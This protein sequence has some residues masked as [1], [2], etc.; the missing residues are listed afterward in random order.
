MEA[1]HLPALLN[2]KVNFTLSLPVSVHSMNTSSQWA[3]L[4][5]K[6][7]SHS[8][9][10]CDIEEHVTGSPIEARIRLVAPV[11]AFHHIKS[12]CVRD[13][14]SR[15][16]EFSNISEKRQEELFREVF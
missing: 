15:L 6:S 7:S 5:Q 8:L 4:N 3:N 16:W 2:L 11:L 12:C 13:I 14:R 10:C 9:S 1:E